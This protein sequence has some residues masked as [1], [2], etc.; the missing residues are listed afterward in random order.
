MAKG[1]LTKDELKQRK[2]QLT[3]EIEK[4]KTIIRA[5]DTSTFEIMINDI[6]KEMLSNVAEEDWKTLKTNKAKVEKFREIVKIIQNQGE[7]LEQ[8]QDELDDVQWELDHYQLSFGED[9][10]EELTPI[11]T[12]FCVDD[13]NTEESGVELLTGDVYGDDIDKADPAEPCGYYLIK[14]SAEM[15]GSF[16]IISNKFEDER[17]LQYPSNRK[18]LTDKEYIG[19]IYQPD[20]GNYDAAISGAKMIADSIEQKESKEETKVFPSV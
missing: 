16:A 14:K 17:L 15:T 13:G 5:S 4:L 3:E 19:N 2:A 11:C 6:K 12:G 10:E 20:N 9:P 1:K 8:K 7:L 18:I